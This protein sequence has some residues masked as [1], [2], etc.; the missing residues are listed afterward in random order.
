MRERSVLEKM[1]DIYGQKN[2]HTKKN[3]FTQKVT[4]NGVVST[5]TPH[6]IERYLE[7][8]RKK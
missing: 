2:R 4:L 3:P 7:E 5:P 8:V 1:Q 6:Q